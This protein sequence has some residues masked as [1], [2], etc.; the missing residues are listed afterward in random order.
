MCWLVQEMENYEVHCVPLHDLVEHEER[1]C[2]CVPTV[3]ESAP[4]RFM[5]VHHSLDGRE[6]YE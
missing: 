5:Y 6:Q 4:G 1:E 3:H 2:V